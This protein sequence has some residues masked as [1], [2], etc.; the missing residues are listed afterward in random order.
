MNRTRFLLPAIFLLSL[1]LIGS[2]PTQAEPIANVSTGLDSNNNVLTSGGLSDAHWTVT[3]QAGGSGAAQSVFPNNADWYGGWLANDSNSDWIARNANITNNGPAP[4]TF[5]TTFDLTGF[6]LSTVVLS[7]GFAA[8]DA[9]TLNLNGTQ[10]SSVPDEA[11]GSLTS[12]SISGSSGD[13]VQG[14]NTLTITITD[15][16]EFLEGV[17]LTGTVT[18][19]ALVPEPATIIGTSVGLLIVAAGRM[20]RRKGRGV[21]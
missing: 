20:I 8:D 11:W 10:I 7:G 4:Y 17:R 3:E 14:L 6:N 18:G 5:T 15:S 13:F 9:G 2:H 1:I 21:V 12:F 19:A 16:D